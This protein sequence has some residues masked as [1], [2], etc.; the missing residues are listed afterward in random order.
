M[1]SCDSVTAACTVR[2]SSSM[3]CTTSARLSSV[4]AFSM[5]SACRA[6]A[7]WKRPVCSPSSPTSRNMSWMQLLERVARGSPLATQLEMVCAG[8]GQHLAG[9]VHAAHTQSVFKAGMQAGAL[10]LGPAVVFG[11]FGQSG[12]QLTAQPRQPF[13]QAVPM[14]KQA[15]RLVADGSDRG[16]M[17]RR[18]AFGSH[19]VGQ[20][21][22]FGGQFG[23]PGF[24]GRQAGPHR[25]LQIV[26]QRRPPPQVR[27]G[28]RQV[29]ANQHRRGIHRWILDAGLAG[30]RRLVALP[31]RHQRL[32]SLQQALGITA[33]AVQHTAQTFLAAPGGPL[34]ATPLQIARQALHQPGPCCPLRLGIRPQGRCWRRCR[35]WSCQRPAG[36]V[37]V[38]AGVVLR[39]GLELRLREPAQRAL[40]QRGGA[41]V[42]GAGGSK[43][44]SRRGTGRCR[45]G[46]RRTAAIDR[47]GPRQCGRS[48]PS[49]RDPRQN[50]S[51]APCA[52][53]RSVPAS[54]AAR[55]A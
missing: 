31:G 51:T 37:R 7:V 8:L 9:G 43:A 25:G 45:R 24:V 21:A 26:D 2:L 42:R 11:Q 30:V 44:G 4:S 41:G 35:G 52:A 22:E 18:G 10:T 17:R 15:A 28:C 19:R 29:R 32:Q 48:R 27:C 12:A 38:G 55:R 47:A 6:V 46:R 54:A 13:H 53:A 36:F 33:A 3:D 1:R 34:A 40:G 14:G 39:R 50:R 16:H 5:A 23:G 49:R 20:A